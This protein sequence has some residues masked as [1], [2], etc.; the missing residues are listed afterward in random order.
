M[1]DFYET[2]HDDYM[3]KKFDEFKLQRKYYD[4]NIIKEYNKFLKGA[5]IYKSKDEDL[6][7]YIKDKI[8]NKTINEE[9]VYNFLEKMDKKLNLDTSL[10]FECYEDLYCLKKAFIKAYELFHYE[11]Y[12]L[13]D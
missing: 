7:L 6:I 3:L 8:Q 5:T 11:G 12:N 4:E 9:F 2:I 10:E 13:K 1:K